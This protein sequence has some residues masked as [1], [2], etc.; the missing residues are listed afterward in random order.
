[1]AYNQYNQRRQAQPPQGSYQPQS[2]QNGWSGG[3]GQQYDNGFPPQEQGHG[4]WDYAQQAGQQ[5]D[6]QNGH[7]RY[8]EGAYY[9]DAQNYNQAQEQY[10]D[11]QQ[12]NQQYQYDPRYRS[13]GRAPNGQLDRRQDRGERQGREK[14]R[15][16]EMDLKTKSKCE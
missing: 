4:G 1:M 8:G 16:P 12:Q 3:G 5:Q 9:S 10:Y 11:Q 7:G 15:P 6:Y 14:H 2:P 13:Q